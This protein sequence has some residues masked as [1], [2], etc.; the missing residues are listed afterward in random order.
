MTYSSCLIEL[1][2]LK[3]K[4]LVLNFQ[5]A[6]K[7]STPGKEKEKPQRKEQLPSKIEEQSTIQD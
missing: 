6:V 7:G 2:G 4:L 1:N 3:Y 5:I